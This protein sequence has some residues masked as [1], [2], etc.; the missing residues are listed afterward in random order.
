MAEPIKLPQQSSG[1]AEEQLVQMYSYLYKLAT[2]LN[3]NFEQIGGG[4]LTDKEIALMNQLTIANETDEDRLNAGMYNWAEAETLK[5]LI[6]KTAQFVKTE[7]EYYRLQLFGEESAEGQFGSWN[8][9]RGLRVDVNPEGVKQTFTYNEVIKGLKTYE[10]NSKNYIKTGELRTE[11]GLPVYGVQVG[12]D[13]VSFS[14]DGTETYNDSNKVAE[15]TADEL[16]FWQGTGVNN[17][18]MASYSSTGITFYVNGVRQLTI[19]GTD[20]IQFWKGN[21]SGDLLLTI[22]ASGMSA[23]IDMVLSAGRKIQAGNWF[24]KNYGLYR[25]KAEEHNLTSLFEMGESSGESADMTAGIYTTYAPRGNTSGTDYYAALIDF[26]TKPGQSGN[27]IRICDVFYD[28]T[29]KDG[30]SWYGGG[31]PAILPIVAN[32]GVLGR[33]A[34]PFKA[35]HIK[36]IYAED[37]Y[38]SNDNNSP[39][40]TQNALANTLLSYVTS[41]SLAS[42][43][44]SYVTSSSLASTLLSYVTTSTLA[45]TLN[46]YVSNSDLQSILYSYVTSNDLQTALSYYVPKSDGYVTGALTWDSDANTGG[47][48][49]REHKMMKYGKVRNLYM[50]FKPTISENGWHTIATINEAN[51]PAIEVLYATAMTAHNNSTARQ[52]MIEHWTSNGATIKMLGISADEYEIGLSYIAMEY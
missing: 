50:Q 7:V 49:N 48:A 10:I 34:W 20:G 52:V 43:L 36:K 24:F 28:A 16:S 15:F 40:I 51:S 31:E 37:I 33:W 2:D 30:G 18:K 21:S 25:L 35:A 6:I 23:A 47:S 19:S 29:I 39:F 8:R 5:S 13:I 32:T 12:K 26:L 41:S 4:T 46:N 11:Q 3:L 44:L 45:T 17:Q 27:G 9:K 42:T 14:E 1:P 22:S 38:D